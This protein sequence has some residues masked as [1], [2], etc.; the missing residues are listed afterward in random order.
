MNRP[1]NLSEMAARW[2]IRQREQSLNAAE[3]ADFEVWIADP[4]HAAEY[5]SIASAMQ[6]LEHPDSLDKLVTAAEQHAFMQKEAKRKRRQSRFAAMLSVVAF[7]VIALFAHHHYQVWQAAPVMQMAMQNPVGKIVTNTLEDGSR[8]TLSA[9]SEMQ[10]TYYRHM[11]HVLLKKGEAVFEVEK[12]PARPFVVQTDMARVTVLGTRFAVNRLPSL[13]RISVDHGRVRVE[14]DK[15]SADTTVPA[16]QLG[17]T[18]GNASDASSQARILVNGQVLEVFA[19]QSNVLVNRPASDAFAFM[20]GRLVFDRADAEEVA[21]T[22]SRYR[23]KPVIA[24]GKQ[25]RN[26][27]ANINIHDIESFIHGLPNIAPIKIQETS[28]TTV[29]Y[30]QRR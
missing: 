21:V 29:I 7:C 17:Q 14:P 24:Q 2:F 13:V 16:A 9:N 6:V 5:Q 1:L 18:S 12:D 28:Q 20:Q 19:N 26:L 23:Q 10:V 8:V 4:A 11:R 3:R 27:S 30:S 25:V 22:L 15:V